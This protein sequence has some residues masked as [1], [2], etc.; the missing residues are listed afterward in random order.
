MFGVLSELLLSHLTN[1]QRH[2]RKYLVNKCQVWIHTFH[3][4]FNTDG[5]VGV[6]EEDVEPQDGRVK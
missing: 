5:S 4:N 3:S 1:S 6:I 2:L